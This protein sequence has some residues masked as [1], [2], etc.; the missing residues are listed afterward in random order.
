MGSAKNQ[1]EHLGADSKTRAV[2]RTIERIAKEHGASIQEAKV[3]YRRML[4]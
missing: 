1:S 4:E 2:H 3:I